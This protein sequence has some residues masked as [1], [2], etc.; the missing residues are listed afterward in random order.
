MQLHNTSRILILLSLTLALSS[1]S[2][3]V[4]AVRLSTLAR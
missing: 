1:H 4:L 3:F 2:R